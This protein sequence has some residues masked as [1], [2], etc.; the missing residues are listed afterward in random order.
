MSGSQRRIRPISITI[1]SLTL[2]SLACRG[3]CCAPPPSFALSVSPV[4]IGL[5]Q[6]R[7]DSVVVL[8]QSVNGFAYE[9]GAGVRWDFNDVFSLNGGYTM[10]WIDFDNATSTPSFDA[11]QLNVGWKF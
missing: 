9:L 10:R 1:V 3:D 8:L 5:Q 7:T 4:S 6:G 11:I 2:V